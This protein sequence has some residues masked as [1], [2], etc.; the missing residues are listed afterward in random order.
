MDVALGAPE[1]AEPLQR[2]VADDPVPVADDARVVLEVELRP[3][4]LEIGLGVRGPAVQRRLERHDDLRHRRRIGGDGGCEDEA[5]RVAC[6]LPGG[7][8]MLRA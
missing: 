5:L 2:A 6:T 1:L 8:Y 4:R 7:V 3:L